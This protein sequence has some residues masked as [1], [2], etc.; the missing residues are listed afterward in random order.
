MWRDPLQELIQ[1]LERVVE[2]PVTNDSEMTVEYLERSYAQFQVET[3]IILFGTREQVAA[4]KHD[5]SD[6]WKARAHPLSVKRRAVGCSRGDRARPEREL[7]PASIAE[8]P[9]AAGASIHE[10]SPHDQEAVARV[11]GA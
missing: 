9:E 5:G 3:D 11:S 4:L 2:L 1:A 7:T 8:V 10:Y 6:D